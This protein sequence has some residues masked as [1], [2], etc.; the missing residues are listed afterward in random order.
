MFF[1]SWGFSDRFANFLQYSI[2][3]PPAHS[4]SSLIVL[5]LC[6]PQFHTPRVS[7][8]SAALAVHG[9]GSYHFLAQQSGT[10]GDSAEEVTDL[11]LFCV[12]EISRPQR[13]LW[14]RVFTGAAKEGGKC[15]G[16]SVANWQYQS[17]Y[18]SRSCWRVNFTSV[19]F[20][21]PASLWIS[22]LWVV[23]LFFLMVTSVFVPVWIST[24]IIIL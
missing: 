5:L 23:G 20:P 7:S 16:Y 15:E 4:P 17:C 2:F 3:P 14:V 11:L 1:Y 22:L 19:Y 21:L 12:M 8:C 6:I 13:A 10:W 9:P 24:Q 18:M